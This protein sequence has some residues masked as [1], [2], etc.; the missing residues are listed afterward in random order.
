MR[1]PGPLPGPL[2]GRGR[3]CP[4][5]RVGEEDDARRALDGDAVGVHDPPRSRGRHSRGVNRVLSGRSIRCQHCD[6][7]AGTTKRHA[8]D[9]CAGDGDDERVAEADGRVCDAVVDGDAERAGREP[10]D[11]LSRGVC[12]QRRGEAPDVSVDV[13]EV[14]GAVGGKGRGF[15][16]FEVL[17]FFFKV[18]WW[19]VWGSTTSIVAK[20]FRRRRGFS[21]EK[22]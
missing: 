18:Q 6:D 9:P 20:L 14:G 10:R 2:P 5:D 19:L 3:G 16:C 21:K 13:R 4:E 8:E 12:C 17:S 7:R 22:T 11:D 1:V 15:C